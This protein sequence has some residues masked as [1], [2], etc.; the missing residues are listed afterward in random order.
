MADTE[1]SAIFIMILL[2]KVGYWIWV[3]LEMW[4]EQ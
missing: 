1:V 2:N 4:S 3:W